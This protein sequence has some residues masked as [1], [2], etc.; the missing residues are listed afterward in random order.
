MSIRDL[1]KMGLLKPES[2]WADR[3]PRSSVRGLLALVWFLLAIG[4]CVLMVYGDGHYWTWIGLG[5]FAVALI[6]FIRQNITSVDAGGL[7]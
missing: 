1:R 5:G 6:G 4:G 2:G 3:L 7:D